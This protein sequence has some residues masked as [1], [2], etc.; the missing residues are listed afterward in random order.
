MLVGDLR[1]QIELPIDSRQFGI[2][3][4]EYVAHDSQ[5]L[6][7]LTLHRPFKQYLRNNTDLVKILLDCSLLFLSID[8]NEDYLNALVVLVILKQIILAAKDIF[9]SVP[10]LISVEFKLAL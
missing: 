5:R 3:L 7:R 10:N 2:Y 1:R 9:S 8:Q 4:L 6:Q